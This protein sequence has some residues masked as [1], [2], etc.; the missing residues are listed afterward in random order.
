M[1]RLTKRKLISD[2][3]TAYVSD[4]DCFDAYSWPKKFMGN[5]I[6]RLADIEDILGDDYDLD[7]LKEIVEADRENRCVVFPVQENEFVWAC[8]EKFPDA[9]MLIYGCFSGMLSDMEEGYAFGKTKEEAETALRRMQDEG[10][11]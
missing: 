11:H 1:E 8:S 9:I 3:N 2:K 4:E 6:D 10:V 7:R 5:A